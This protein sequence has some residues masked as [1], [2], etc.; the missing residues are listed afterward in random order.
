MAIKLPD[1]LP[2]TV[3]VTWVDSHGH[4]AKVDGA[5]TWTSGDTAIFTVAADSTDSTIAT[6][7]AAGNLDTAQ[8]TASADADLGSGTTTITAMADITVIAGSA[9][10][11]TIGVVP[12]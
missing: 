11:G 3:K 8:L 4:A 12:A 1:D 2:I 6:L 9:V 5:T 7:T 10:A